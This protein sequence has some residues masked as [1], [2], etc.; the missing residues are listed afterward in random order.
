MTLAISGWTCCILVG[1]LI[2]AGLSY[3]KVDSI[4]LFLLGISLLLGG[5]V[6]VLG[7]QTTGGEKLTV[8]GFVVSGLGIAVSVSGFIRALLKAYRK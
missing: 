2:A 3:L 4:E 8:A 6:L 1:L 5:I 7:S